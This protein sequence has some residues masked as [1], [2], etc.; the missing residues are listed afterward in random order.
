MIICNVIHGRGFFSPL[1]AFGLEQDI[2]YKKKM[3][4]ITASERAKTTVIIN[5]LLKKKI[6]LIK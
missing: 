4:N 6:M 1:F 3:V 2:K 5:Y